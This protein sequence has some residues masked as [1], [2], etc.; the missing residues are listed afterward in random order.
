MGSVRESLLST[1]EYDA[2]REW[3][4]TYF[5]EERDEQVGIIAAEELLDR[6]LADVG[7]VVYNRALDDAR[8]WAVRLLENAEIDFE[9]LRRQPAREERS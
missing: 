4:Q 6:F 1:R 3:I 2:A 7:V 5:R 8:Q 9:G